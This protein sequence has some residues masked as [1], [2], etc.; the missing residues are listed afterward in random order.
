MK[1]ETYCSNTTAANALSV[2]LG[3]SL[4]VWFS[5]KTCVAI[6]YCG[7]TIVC[8]NQWGPTTGKHL[9]AIDGGGAEAKALRMPREKFVSVCESMEQAGVRHAAYY[10]W[11]DEQSNSR[12]HAVITEAH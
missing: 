1:I 11:H 5:Y 3:D 10:P 9:N 8:E 2:T 7:N 12:S 4:K 6:S